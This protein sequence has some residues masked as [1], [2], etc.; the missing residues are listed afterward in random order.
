MYELNSMKSDT[1]N[2]SRRK[3]LDTCGSILAAGSIAGVAGVTLFKSVKKNKS[4]AN[5]EQYTDVDLSAAVPYKKTASFSVAGDINCFELWNDKLIVA[6]QNN[7]HICSLS[8]NILNSFASG[9]DLRDIAVYDGNIYMLF[10]SGI[11]V[12]DMDGKH[13]RKWGA[14]NNLSDYC[15][16][17]VA[18]GSVFVTDAAFKEICKYS[19]DGQFQKIIKS[20]NRFIIP[21]YTFGIVAIDDVIYCSNSGRHQVEMFTTDGEYLGAFGQAG[22]ETGSFCGCCNPVHL[23]CTP[24]GDII[25][26]EKGTPRI[27]CYG[28]DGQFR[29]LLLDSNALDSGNKACD[30]KILGNELFVADKNSVSIFQV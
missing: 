17:T 7:I 30:V 19:V 20:P 21:S 2:T 24:N 26:S 25:T 28:R 10:P 27:S 29:S 4:I 14:Q 9:I 12:C 13:I 3:F 23:T 15:S 16:F 11:A 22:I 1:P 6:T 18:S 5:D 8:G